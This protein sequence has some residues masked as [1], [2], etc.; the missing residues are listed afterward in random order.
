MYVCICIRVY[1]YIYIH[2]YT[3]TYIYVYIL[4]AGVDGAAVLHRLV[5]HDGEALQGGRLDG[6]VLA[7]HLL[8]LVLCLCY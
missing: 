3:I 6:G 1:I 5:A 4:Q 2:T 7:A 8:I